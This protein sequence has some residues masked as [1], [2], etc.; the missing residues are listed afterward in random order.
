MFKNTLI[1]TAL[2]AALMGVSYAEMSRSEVKSEEER[3][4]ATFRSNKAR[5]ANLSGNTKDICMAEAKGAEK[6]AKAELD[7]RRK[8]NT[9]QTRF[10]V[11][12]VRAEAVYDIAKQKC[13]D[14]AGNDKDVCMRDAK[15]ALTAAMSDARVELE[16]A[17][18]SSQA[19][20]RV[21]EARIDAA[22]AKR[23]ADYLAARERCDT[24]SGDAKQR[25]VADA[26]YQFGMN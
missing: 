11:R 5:C 26:K 18:A 12:I 1:T 2:T 15:A 24:Y 13:E 14:R 19:N 4:A 9:A 17:K 6:I 25:C 21:S 3:I 8:N 16:V 23:K 22:Q 7:A 10:D 20:D